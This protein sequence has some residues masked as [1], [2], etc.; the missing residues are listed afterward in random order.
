MNQKNIRISTVVALT[1]AAVAVAAPMASAAEG[2]HDI[3]ARHAQQT[4]QVAE[5]KD[6]IDLLAAIEETGFDERLLALPSSPSAQQVVEAMY[7][8]NVDAQ[9]VALPLLIDP[10]RAGPEDI[11]SRGL[12]DWWNKGK[13]IA[14]CIGAVGTFVAGNGL[15]ISKAAKFGGVVKGAKLIA[16]AGNREERLKLAVA[17]FGNVSGVAG[18]AKACG[19]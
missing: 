5:A 8:G 3:E 11:E 14:A 9:R 13:R 4:R 19:G 1:A 15:L 2:E 17:I 6:Q 12:K 7:P 16:Q 10:A 18:L